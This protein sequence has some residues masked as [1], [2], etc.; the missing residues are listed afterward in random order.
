[1]LYSF[2]NLFT[3]IKLVFVSLAKARRARFNISISKLS[4]SIINLRMEAKILCSTKYSKMV[5]SFNP[6]IA[7]RNL[8][9]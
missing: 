7:I 8:N 5:D 6:K 4:E 2:N 3:P 1:M 9:V